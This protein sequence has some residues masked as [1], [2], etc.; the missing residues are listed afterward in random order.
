LVRRAPPLLNMVDNRVLLESKCV[1][2]LFLLLLLLC[3]M[4]LNKWY[5][6]DD[7]DKVELYVCMCILVY[8]SVDI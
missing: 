5:H 3:T 4:D 8:F 7:L 2:L 1:L 6:R